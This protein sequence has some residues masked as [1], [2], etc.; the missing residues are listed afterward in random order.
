M[1][2]KKFLLLFIILFSFTVIAQIKFNAVTEKNSYALN[3]SIQL[4]FE[5][6]VDA[7]NFLLPRIDGFKVDGPFLMMQNYNINGR[8]GFLKTYKYFLT[9]KKQGEFVIKEAQI[10]YGGKVFKTTP[11]KIKITKAIPIPKNQNQYNPNPYDPFDDPFFNQDQPQ[12]QQPTGYGEGV[13]IVAEVSNKNP[14]VSE[15]LKVIYKIYFDPRVQIGNISNIKKPKYN[16]FWSQFYDA[17]R[18]AIQAQYKGKTYGMSVLGSAVLYPLEAGNKPIEPFTFDAE[19]E[20]PTTE[21]DIIGNPIYATANRKLTSGTQIINVKAL[22]TVGKPDNFFGAVGTFDF[23]VTPSKT[24]LKSNESL[25]LNVTVSGNGNLK[26]FSLPKPEIPSAL[27]IYDPEHNENVETQLSGMTGSINDAYTIVPQYKGKYP[28]KPLKFSYFDLNSKTYKTITSAPLLIDVLDGPDFALASKNKIINDK[29]EAVVNK[30][31]ANIK[32][33]TNFSA[34]KKQDFLGS[35][36]FYGLLFL[37]FLLL[38]V[39]VII[40]KKKQANDADVVGNRIKNSS[41]LVKKYLSEAKK[42]QGN[43][44]PFYIALEKAMHNFLK[45]KLNIETF[46]M[47]KEKITEI[48]LLRNAN[49]ETVNQFINLTE[50]CEIARFAPATSGTIQQDFDKAV[51]IISDLEKQIK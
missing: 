5:M 20:Y 22:P 12:R 14:Y 42:Q 19:V 24:A 1:T 38:P 47:S 26:L 28:I 13:F 21:R 32:L 9:P 29:N 27:E 50:N 35:K 41:K 43:K 48:L 7:D 25:K 40:R 46:D 23:K 44:E 17:N 18:P 2:M 37:P 3:E 45:A 31:F 10:E 15:P 30:P 34:L 39:I 6:N 16:S 51:T 4:S 36:M 8:R 11:I 33:K 49:R